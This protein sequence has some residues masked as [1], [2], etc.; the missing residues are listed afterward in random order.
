MLFSP[1]WGRFPAPDWECAVSEDP[2][3]GAVCH[4]RAKRTS[5]EAGEGATQIRGAE[6]M[7]VVGRHDKDLT[8][9]RGVECKKSAGQIAKSL[10]PS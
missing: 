1:L 8:L 10:W 3:M 6:K 5:A 2:E 4:S 7:L 9:E